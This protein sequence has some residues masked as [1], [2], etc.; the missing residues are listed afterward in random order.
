MMFDIIGDI[1]GYADKL[2]AL[3]QKLGYLKKNNYYYHHNRKALFIGDYIDRGPKIRE[4][5]E[6]VKQMVDNESAI[7]L[8]GN[9]EYNALCFHLKKKEGGHLRQHSINSIV[10][11][12]E[13]LKQFQN[14]QKEYEYY[15]EWFKTLP[16]FYETEK[17]R[18]VHACWDNSNI[19]F[20]KKTLKDNRLTNELIYESVQTGTELYR[21]IDETL[22][23]K[24]FKLPNG[25][26]YTDRDGANRNEFR[27]KWWE[28]PVELTY[29]EISI[30]TNLNLPE[31]SIDLSLLSSDYYNY[32][33]E[34]QVFFGHYWLSGEP[35]LYNEKIC[36]LDY[37]VAKGGP[38]VAYR[39]QDENILNKGSLIWV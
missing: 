17:F 37:S 33:E 31:I 25:R 24:E 5:L 20:L 35:S 16:L 9:H 6:I 11:H 10:Q 8:M 3:L 28:N 32:K 23:G 19:I 4:T 12:F 18:A 27:I 39:L 15:V 2:E 1:H 38:L 22:K 29:K 34:K 21:A 13:T 26:S 30:E 14:K 36:C 7:A